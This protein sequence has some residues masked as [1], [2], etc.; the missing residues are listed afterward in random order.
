VNDTPAPVNTADQLAGTWLLER[1]DSSL[2]VAN[3]R[4]ITLTIDASGQLS[5]AGACNSYFGSLSVD[6]SSITVGPIGSTEMACPG[7]A[8]AADTEYFA[9]LSAVTAANVADDRLTLTGEDVSLVYAARDLE[10]EI[11]GTWTVI[12]V[13]N[14]QAVSS[15]IAPDPVLTIGSDGTIGIKGCNNL[16]SR[17]SL[18]DG[19]FSVD[20]NIMSTLIGCPDDLAQQDQALSSALKDVRTVT[21]KGDQITFL[22]ADGTILLTASRTA[23]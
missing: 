22:N 4:P 7:T 3:D 10:R 12:S 2:T 21:V 5:G 1:A 15:V 23:D 19:T 18:V 8:M 6:G 14:G 9:A 17:W 13:N 20:E 11:I 16:G